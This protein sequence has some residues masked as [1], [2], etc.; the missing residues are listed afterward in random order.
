MNNFVTTHLWH[1]YIDAGSS[2]IYEVSYIISI[3]SITFNIFANFYDIHIFYN[4]F[5]SS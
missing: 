1:E 2:L 4:F 5:D 3:K